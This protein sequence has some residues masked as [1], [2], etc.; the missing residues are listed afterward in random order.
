MSRHTRKRARQSKAPR[1]ITVLFAVF[2]TL[3]ALCCTG[4]FAGFCLATTWLSDLPDYTSLDLYAKSG[5][6]TIYAA[7]R[8]T[9]LGKITLENRIEV[10]KNEV[11][12]YVLDGTVATEDERFYNH[13]GVDMVGIG[14]A[15]V[16]NIASSGASEGASTITQQL[17]RNTVLLS[18]MNDITVKRKIREMYL[19]VKVE[20]A[21]SKDQILMM[22][23]NVINYG[24]GCYGIETAS[25][26]YFGVSA[27][28]LTLSQ[29]A[30][31]VAIPQ[32]PTANNPRKHYDTALQRSH[33]VLQRMLSNGYITQ[34]EYDE[35]IANE[36]Q[37]VEKSTT[38]DDVNNIA[39]HFVDYV[40]QLLQSDDFNISELSQGGLSIYTTLDVSCQKAANKSIKA[41][42]KQFDSKLDSSL[43]SIDPDNGHIVAMVG[44]K[45][46]DKNQFNLATQMSRQ[47]GSSFKTFTL[48]AALEAGVD[49][50]NTYIASAIVAAAVSAGI[51]VAATRVAAGVVSAG[52]VVAVG[53]L[54][55]AAGV[56]LL[57]VVFFL[58]GG[59]FL[60]SRRTRAGRTAV[61]VIVSSAISV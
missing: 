56:V 21:Y 26:D 53:S 47:A 6:S 23:L 61:V 17:V 1:R 58:V 34:A 37:L 36:P 57:G 8:E 54:L 29:A 43:T 44:G 19:A 4:I 20:E 40:K 7:D 32:S 14:R 13:K 60:F 46:Y 45:D 22:Y 10:A 27:D 39:P 50:D 5:Y 15:L 59:R 35:A 18:E 33:L 52:I 48:V 42:L 41:T 12:E 2:G 11:S 49:P 16:V 30:M 31:L 38:D 3:L 28:E 55:A 25:N 24:D 9:V 51:G